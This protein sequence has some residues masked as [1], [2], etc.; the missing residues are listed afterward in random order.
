MRAM[1]HIEEGRMEKKVYFKNI[2]FLRFMLAVMITVLHIIHI[3]A[4]PLHDS[5]AS[6]KC[7]FSIPSFHSEIECTAPSN[8]FHI[9]VSGTHDGYLIINGQVNCQF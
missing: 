4:L 2:D 9:I 5:Q 8:D 3:A 1:Y 6:L 7:I